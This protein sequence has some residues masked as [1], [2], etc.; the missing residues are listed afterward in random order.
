M[1]FGLVSRTQLGICAVVT[2][3]YTVNASKQTVKSNSLWCVFS[4]HLC[5]YMKYW[6]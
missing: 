1:E 4:F 2:S 5:L 3:I 6:K